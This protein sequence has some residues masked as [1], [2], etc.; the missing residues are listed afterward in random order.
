MSAQ[1]APEQ[2]GP[3]PRNPLKDP[4]GTRDWAKL[5]G[6]SLLNARKNPSFGDLQCFCLFIGYSRSGHT[7]VG[8]M[9]NA[10]PEVVIAHELDAVN[11]VRHH[12]SRGQLFSLLLGRDQRFG[13]MGRHWSGYQYEVDGQYQGRY[14]RLRVLGDKRARSAALLL[15]EHPDLL[16]RIRRTVKV[17]IRVIHVT[18]NPFDNI[19]TEA[20]RHKLSLSQGTAW[21]ERC[22]ESVATVRQMLDPSDLVDIRYETFIEEPSASLADLCRFLGVDADPDY[23]AACAKLVW[24]STNRTRD[25]IEWS[26]DERAGVERVIERYEVLGSYSFDH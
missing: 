16:D 5:Y 4:H 24:P 26:A 10:H 12:F 22:C 9:L 1:P 21:Y 25:S 18:R 11:F 13:S 17:P 19:A 14:E 2:S 3:R 8:A 15:A 7:L 20:R 6:S 23:L